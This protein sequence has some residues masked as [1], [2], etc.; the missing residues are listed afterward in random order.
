MSLDF[1]HARLPPFR[2]QEEDTEILVNSPYLFI[3][4]EMRTGKTKIVID[5]AQFLYLQGSTDTVITVAPSPVRDVWYDSDI[6]ELKKHLWLNI[7]ATI[8]EFHQKIRSW[9]HG[10]KDTDRLR[11]IVTNFEYLRS[12]KH[13][14]ELFPYC[15]QSTLLVIDESS[16]VK[17]YKAKQ[18]QACFTL[19]ERCGRIV[20]LNGT[21]ISHSP[22]DLFSQGN[23]LHPSILDCRY[24]THYRAQYAVMSPVRGPGGKALKDKWGNVISTATGWKN[25]EEIQKR[26]APYVIRRLQKDCLDLP[27]KL[28]PV[29]LTAT[30][31][32]ETWRHYREMRD[33]CIVEFQ[34][35]KTISIAS[36]AVV[37]AMRLAQITSGF[38]GGIQDALQDPE[39]TLLEW[40][41]EKED[42][43]P[44]KC[45]EGSGESLPIIATPSSTFK[46]VGREKL[47]VVL[48]FLEQ[49]L[50]QDEISPHVLVWCRFRPELFRLLQNVETKFPEFVVG[51]ICGGQKKEERKRTMELLHP[52]STPRKKPVLVGG[53]FGTGSFGLNF[54]GAQYSVNCSFDYS[55]GKFLQAGDR[56]YGPGM[57]GPAAYFDVIA[58][59]PQ[60]QKTIDH[61]IVKARREREDI[62]NWVSADWVRALSDGEG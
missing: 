46:E 2:H 24:I 17:N 15:S 21:P 22:E 49:R 38:I 41:V 40:D 50:E 35:S 52:S 43:L 5:A 7:P 59:G 47:D 30:L 29:T 12:D 9:T 55:L 39:E 6:G 51:A 62:A 14:A 60:G 42:W 54:T 13:L 20:E 23:L 32:P 58:K 1:K 34:Q 25:L 10:P 45:S 48:W 8:I 18:T 26:F 4:S 56:V 33:E 53:T 36:Q 11:W 61:V 44:R 19:R 3:T 31:T 28:D 57:I 37:K 16:F 27:P